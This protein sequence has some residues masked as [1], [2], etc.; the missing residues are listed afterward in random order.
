MF[1]LVLNTSLINVVMT[2][3]VRYYQIRLNQWLV[4]V[5]P[6]K[7]DAFVNCLMFKV[8]CVYTRTSCHNPT[9]IFS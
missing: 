4:E 9:L 8:A 3:I 5:I 1:D 7:K 2:I 6:F